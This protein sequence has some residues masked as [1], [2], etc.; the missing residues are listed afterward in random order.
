MDS[1][2]WFRGELS[3]DHATRVLCIPHAGGGASSFNSWGVRFGREVGLVKLQLP[4]REDRAG[5]PALRSLEAIM[6][7]LLPAAVRHLTDRPLVIYGHSLGALIG[8][9]LAGRLAAEGHPPG[10]L[11][12]SGRRAP[13]CSL[14]GRPVC[15]L[16]DSEFIDFINRIGGADSRLLSRPSWREHYVKLMRSDLE[17]TDLH[18]PGALRPLPLPLFAYRGDQDPLVDREEMEQWSAQTT[19]AYR[20]R[21]LPG[22]HFFAEAGREILFADILGQAHGPASGVR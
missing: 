21:V 12:V 18:R 7:E 3:G 6:E 4:G 8:F 5:E 22:G 17:V 13:Q 14:R 10:A 11:L 19:A 1:R 15:E 9:E 16:S 2:T 20:F